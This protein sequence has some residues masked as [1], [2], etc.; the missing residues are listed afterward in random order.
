ML[1][2]VPGVEK[3]LPRH[4]TSMRFVKTSMLNYGGSGEVGGGDHRVTFIDV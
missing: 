1:I 3:H 2:G 4:G